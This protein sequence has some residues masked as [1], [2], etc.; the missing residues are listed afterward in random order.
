ME[1]RPLLKPYI[2][3]DC[4]KSFVAGGHLTRHR[5]V[6]SGAKE[7]MCWFP[8]CTKRSSRK[9][10]LWQ[11]YRLHFDVR[12]P[13]ELRRMAPE[14]RRRRPRVTRI[15]TVDAAGSQNTSS[16]IDHSPSTSCSSYDSSISSEDSH[17]AFHDLFHAHNALAPTSPCMLPS[18]QSPAGFDNL[19]PWL[20]EQTYD[21]DTSLDL[22]QCT[23]PVDVLDTPAPFT[24]ALHCTPCAPSYDPSDMFPQPWTYNL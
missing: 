7:Y 2:C 6:H 20:Y 12:N 8:N 14:K 1:P 21:L 17:E 18:P 3:D 4:G 23:S 16:P 24:R 11:H 13:E 9:D 19:F 15:A 5:R 10:N 22:P